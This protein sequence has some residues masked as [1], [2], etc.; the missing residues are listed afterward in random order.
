M[1]GQV[2]NGGENRD[3]TKVHGLD[4]LLRNL[5]PDEQSHV[6]Q[7]TST[8]SM[9]GNVESQTTQTAVS[10]EGTFL[11]NLLHQ[12]MPVVSQHI[13]VANM[14]NRATQQPSTSVENQDRGISSQQSDDPPSSKQQKVVWLL[15][16]GLFI[17]N[18]AMDED[19]S[20]VGDGIS[21]PTI[22]LVTSN[23][24][25]NIG[26]SSSLPVGVFT[27]KINENAVYLCYMATGIWVV[28]FLGR[29][30][31]RSVNLENKRVFVAEGYCW[32]RTAERQAS[33]LRSD[34]LKA[35]LRQDVAYFDLNGTS[36]AEIITS[37]SSDSL[38]IQEVISEKV[39]V[40]LMNMSTFGGAYVVAFIL[41]W[42]LAIVGFPFAIILVIPGLIYGKVLMNLSRK[43]REEYNKAGM[44]AEQA[45]SS[46]RTVYSFVGEIK[47]L[48]EYS[49]ALQGTVKLGLKQ[50]LAKGIV[51]GSN[52]VSYAVLSFL[53]WYGS[54]L[55]MYHGAGGG[56]VFTVAVGIA[57]GGLSLGF[58]LS[59]MKY[60]SDAMA[61]SERMREVIKR[62]PRIDS[63]NMEGEIL[64]E[65]SGEVEFKHVKFAYPSRPGSE[66]FKDFNLK[67]PAGKTVALV[68][69][70]GSGKSTVIALLQRF[71]D[72]QSGEI[73]VDGM[74][75]DKL[76]LKWLR[77]QMGLVS[78]EPA[79]FATSIKENILFGKEDAA[80]EEVIE[81]AKAS[82]AHNFIS[83][84][85][86]AY[87]TQVGERGVQMSGGQKQRL[88]IARAIIKSPRI[89]LLDEATSALDSESERVVQDAL[90]RVSIGR[91]TIIIAHRLSTIRY[92]DM[93]V[94]VQDGKVVESGSHDDLFQIEDGFYTSLVHLQKTK[95]NNES[96]NAY[97][98][99]PSSVS[100]KF[101]VHNI[102]NRQP[103][104]VNESN[105]A[106]LVN[107]GGD[108]DFTMQAG[109]EILVPSFR[110]LLA[111]NLP[112]WK[113]ALFGCMGAI[114]FGAIQPL[115]AFTMG[116]MVSMY[117][118]ANHDEIKHKTMIYAL[119]FAG[120]AVF[121]MVI[122]IIQH[123]S[124]AAMGEYLTKR[125]REKMLSKILTFEIG[126]FD[127]D[128]NSTGAICSRLTKDA[129]VVR[130]LVG[131]RCLLLIQTFSTVTI[132]CTMGLVIAWRLAF[133]LIAVQPTIIICFYYKRVLLKSMV[134]KTMKSQEESSK[135]AA[136]AVSNLRTVT[137]FSSQTRILKMLQETQK[138]PMRESRRQAWYGGLGLGLSQSLIVCTWALDFWYGAKLISD[139]HLGVK[140]LLQTFM[141][142]IGI[143]RTIAD[144]GTMTNDLAKGSDAVQSVFAVLDRHTLIEP[145]DPDGE[146]LE[147]ITGHVEI[148]DVDFAYPARPDIMIFKGF[149]IDIEAGK[150]TALVGQSGSGKS[151]IIGLIERFYDPMNGVVKVDGR[152][153]RSYHLRTL[154]K[155]IALVSQEQTL[156]PGTIRENIMYGASE[157]VSESEI[158]EAAKVANVHDFVAVLKDGYNTLCGDQGVQL[159]GGQKQRI[160]IARAIL[161]NPTILLLDEATSAL[162]S[163]S[164]K[165]VQIALERMMVGR[166]SVV[167]AHRLS[168]IQ[169]C[170]TIAVLEKG[171][172]IEQGNHG[173]LLEKGPTGAYYSLVH[174]QDINSYS[175]FQKPS[176]LSRFV[177]AI[178]D[179]RLPLDLHRK[180]EVIDLEGNM[181]NGNLNSNFRDLESLRAEMNQVDARLAGIKETCAGSK[182]FLDG[183]VSS[184]EGIT[185]DAKRKWQEFYL[186]AEN[187]AKDNADF[188]AAKHCRME[189]LLQKR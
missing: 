147:I 133:V 105:S 54:R 20:A 145:E 24:I 104:I 154:R 31:I 36:T 100:L 146:K 7:G 40:F 189:L 179:S 35:V 120:L 127:Q 52:G 78:Q 79:L 26:D 94:V 181:L 109:Q 29:I 43:I 45:I 158:I 5:F 123:Y 115:Y 99:E 185:T 74:R 34:Y 143:G 2:S 41:L 53:C 176:E 81:A 125:V 114:L 174:L 101:D 56:T 180:L 18:A 57:S 169:S 117:F 14:D 50:G 173:S 111:M 187:D 6:F 84:L 128:E 175:T 89:L 136:E 63:Y 62:V 141:I 93:I 166:T 130:S 67:V 112:E 138:A 135:L 184:V 17:G 82:N 150:S 66:I 124:F 98:S 163:P 88:A 70:S 170:N 1:K 46:V 75:I 160:A 60:F 49:A 144:A 87:D 68:G 92:A 33:R 22:L 113:Q 171:E 182:T 65:V 168:T 11:S 177:Y 172:V 37:I 142:I 72:P 107:R 121:C 58:G 155:Y 55:V 32:T 152:D 132:S 131:D 86:Q 51:I 157:E 139:G 21:M 148:C 188:S 134:Q 122:N 106:N 4:Q 97:Q 77:S 83:Q 164:E 161:K 47:T 61:A 73:C 137:A 23:I 126:W 186:Q 110:R 25:N 108:V 12:I 71:Y 3:S 91:T 151:T 19:P 96:P 90:D 80:M 149:S 167:V 10:D 59:D 95:Q 103:L 76:Q 9:S 8:D 69:A 118:L 140:E 30:L 165:I 116:S 64:K 28:C 13:N 119:F 39:P 178:I 153:V 85:P 183:H 27:D 44:V 162:D 102:S 42:R 38:V 129:N 156:F 159:S 48:T 16:V 15:D